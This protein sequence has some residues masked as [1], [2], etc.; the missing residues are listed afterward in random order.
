[1]SAFWRAGDYEGERSCVIFYFPT[2]RNSRLT[3]WLTSRGRG[4]PIMLPAALQW[5]GVELLPQWRKSVMHNVKRH[6]I[7][8]WLAL[9]LISGYNKCMIRNIP[10][11]HTQKPAIYTLIPIIFRVRQVLVVLQVF[12][13]TNMKMTVFGDVASCSLV[14]TDQSFRGAHCQHHQGNYGDRDRWT[15]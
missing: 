8:G 14:D 5:R 12:T 10:P 11:L 6:N 3:D 7:N 2:V 4:I 13:A 1:M 15:K 9:V